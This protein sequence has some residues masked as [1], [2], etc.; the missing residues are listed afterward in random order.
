MDDDN[1]KQWDTINKKICL[2]RY[3]YLEKLNYSQKQI[4][5]DYIFSDV[6]DHYND[7]LYI[8]GVKTF[9]FDRYKK[10]Y[11]DKINVKRL[12]ISN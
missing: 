3:D 4:Y 10:L 5:N 2:N 11:L 1:F 9:P 8:N 12:N 7:I 6:Y